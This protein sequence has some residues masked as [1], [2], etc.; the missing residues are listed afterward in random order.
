MIHTRIHSVS[1]KRRYGWRTVS[2]EK[3]MRLYDIPERFQLVSDPS[4]A[5]CTNEFGVVI[6]QEYALRNLEQLE[7]HACFTPADIETFLQIYTG[8][9]Y[10]DFAKQKLASLGIKP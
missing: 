10:T 5:L 4:K 8:S 6:K 3:F 7:A 1:L 9:E 2:V